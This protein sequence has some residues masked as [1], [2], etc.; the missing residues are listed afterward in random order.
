MDSMHTAETVA[1]C[2]ELY[3]YNKSTSKI[4]KYKCVIHAIRSVSLIKY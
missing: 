2:T 1:A 4:H 3:T